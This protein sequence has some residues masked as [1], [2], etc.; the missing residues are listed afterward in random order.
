MFKGSSTHGDA[1]RP[2]RLLVGLRRSAVGVVLGLTACGGA[3]TSDSSPAA[4]P[5]ATTSILTITTASPSSVTSSVASE[6]GGGALQGMSGTSE[7]VVVV[8]VGWSRALQDFWTSRGHDPLTDTDFAAQAYDAVVVIALAVVAAGSDGSTH[9]DEIVGVT[10]DGETCVSFEECRDVIDAGGDP[11]YD[12]VSGRHEFDATGEPRVATYS[13]L[14]FGA[15]NRIMEASV[16]DTIEVT[17]DEPDG[18]VATRTTADRPGDDRLVIGSVFPLT[19]RS[20]DLG[21]AMNAGLEF[22]LHT[23]NTSGGVL[24]RPLEHVSTDSGDSDASA[25]DGVDRLVAEQVDAIV[26]AMSTSTTLA[27]IDRVV[28]AGITL[29][30]PITTSPLWSTYPDDGLYFRNSPSDVLQGLALARRIVDDGRTTVFVIQRADVYGES[31]TET[32]TENLRSVGVTVLGVESFTDGSDPSPDLFFRLIED[33]ADAVVLV[34]F[35]EGSEIVRAAIDVGVGPTSVAWYG[36][37]GV[38]SDRFG[39]VFDAGW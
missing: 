39:E 25:E 13:A 9:A 7:P 36:T 24:G 28:T 12:G 30:S 15:D 31:I 17:R 20:T 38:M 16:E 3:E 11:D 29:F 27:V 32:L 8:D 35:D 18:L 26:G 5:S 37:D 22:A 23:I 19:G 6:V 4:E 10:R 14:E 2:G 1:I 33:P 34:S 21:T